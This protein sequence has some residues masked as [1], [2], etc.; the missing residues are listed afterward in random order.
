MKN[1]LTVIG[2]GLAGSEAAW[3][4]AERGV[5]VVLYE[6]RPVQPT[7]VHKTDQ[8]A[9]LVCS[10]SLG[11]NQAHSAP[12]LLKEELRRL[13][14]LV[15][16]SAD[17]HAV[18]AGSALAVDRDLFS[19]AITER[20][21]THPN[22]TFKREEVTEIPDEGPVILATGPLTSKKLSESISRRIGQNYL[23]FYDALSPIIDAQSIDYDKAFFASR[24]DKGDADYL[25][26]P[27]NKEEYTALVRELCLAKKVPLQSFEKPI[28]FEGCMPVEEL[29]LRGEKTLAFGPMKPVGLPCPKTGKT[30]YAVVQL[31]HENK[32][33]TAF[34]I[35]GFQTKLTYP[36]QKRVFRMIPGLENAE[37]F[38]LGAI[39]RNTFINAPTLLT[40]QLDLKSNPGIYFA[41]QIIGVEGYVES[42]AMGALAGISA[43]K[44][45]CGEPYSPP[46]LETALGSLINYV[47]GGR[48]GGAYQPMNI[49]YGLFPAS[50]MKTKNKQLRNE[51]IMQKALVCMDEWMS[52]NFSQ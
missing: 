45:L 34:N 15:I 3:Q 19:S 24:Y 46:P 7:Q 8:C 44:R 6:M 18:P 33:G 31:R 11:G 28:Y 40:P 50:S 38:R 47:A 30:F 1:Y 48:I 5:K 27:L 49:N 29:A 36:E 17:E 13:N 35:V 21:S 39:H 42:T 32:E 23:Y 14:S 51:Q 16:A 52:A 2:S 12:F 41:G 20:L 22:I 37:F 4:A 26:C 43:V 9:E 25:N 10:N